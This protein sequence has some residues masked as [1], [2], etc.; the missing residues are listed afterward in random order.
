MENYMN[1][2][3]AIISPGGNDTA[4][5]QGIFNP[6]VKKIINDK[7]MQKYPNVEQV[8]F[9][10]SNNKSIRLDMAGGEF[11]GNATRSLAY[12]LLAQKEGLVNISVS[13]TDKLLSAG[14]KNGYSFSQI[15]LKENNLIEK[16]D[17]NIWKVSLDG[18]THLVVYKKTAKAELETMKNDGMQL[19][20][21][22]KLDQTEKA[23]GVMY[24][25]EDF[26][27]IPIVWVRD[28]QTLFLETACGSGT[29]AVGIVQLV[30]QNK[31][32]LLTTLIQPS[33]NFITTMTM[34]KN[35]NYYSEIYGTTEI[36][37]SRKELII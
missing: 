26:K 25:M 7:I 36:V 8:G 14:V 9:Y 24:V 3:Y 11:C 10:Q 37:M 12:L 30:K 15:P 33:N 18:I 4:L 17:K 13:G 1:I 2:Q 34:K 19:L 16:I 31:E 20:K 29:A 22:T 5:V 23:A 21:K 28:I 35:N 6:A 32:R 27:I